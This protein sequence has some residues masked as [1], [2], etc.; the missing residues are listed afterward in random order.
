MILGRALPQNP[1]AERVL[2]RELYMHWPNYRK[3]AAAPLK[4]SVACTFLE[5]RRRGGSSQPVPPHAEHKMAALRDSFH[6]HLYMQRLILGPASSH[7]RPEEPWLSLQRS[8]GSY[9]LS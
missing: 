6:R 9:T 3:N 4:N 7:T 8:V 5:V 1:E 2:I